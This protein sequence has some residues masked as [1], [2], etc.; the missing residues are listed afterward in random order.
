MLA[1][2]EFLGFAASAI[3]STQLVSLATDDPDA[4]T[5]LGVAVALEDRAAVMRDLHERF[6][7]GV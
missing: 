5:L 7:E 6:A 1:T 2:N 4:K 3:R